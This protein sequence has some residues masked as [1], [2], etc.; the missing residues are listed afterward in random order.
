M[1]RLTKTK[2]KE[3]KINRMSGNANDDLH[4]I[5]HLAD[6][7]K[8]LVKAAV[9]FSLFFLAVL[10]TIN[11]WFPYVTK[12]NQLVILSPLEVIS[13][14]MSISVALTFG[15]ALPFLAHFLWQFIR[16]GLTEREGRFLRMYAPLM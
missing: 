12:A 1:D 10:C 7:R 14:Y 2:N 8:Q 9:V 13:F 3:Q 16:P 11:Y 15:L 5:E 6:L 4:A